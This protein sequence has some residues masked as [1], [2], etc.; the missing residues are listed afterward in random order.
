[1]AEE[2]NNSESAPEEVRVHERFNEFN[3]G[4]R[5]IGALPLH[6]QKLEKMLDMTAFNNQCAKLIASAIKSLLYL[7][8]FSQ[9][10]CTRQKVEKRPLIC[11]GTTRMKTRDVK[12]GPPVLMKGLFRIIFLHVS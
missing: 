8:L 3:K 5:N 6:V 10:T 11:E 12:R 1:M 7:L 9:V 2:P 4:R